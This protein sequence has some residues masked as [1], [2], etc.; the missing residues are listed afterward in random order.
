MRLT[1]HLCVP[2]RSTSH[3]PDCV[4]KRPCCLGER[5][6]ASFQ[7]WRGINRLSHEFRRRANSVSRLRLD[8]KKP[9]T[10]SLRFELFC[11]YPPLRC[12]LVLSP[13]PTK[14][15]GARIRFFYPSGHRSNFHSFPLAVGKRIFFIRLYLFLNTFLQS[16]QFTISE[17]LWRNKKV[18]GH[19]QGA[20]QSRY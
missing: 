8:P 10:F 9:D 13:V 18:P 1:V 3:K 20:N 17:S 6:F 16:F 14:N 5:R 15:R 4:D 7:E 2:H 19:C 11:T 12:S